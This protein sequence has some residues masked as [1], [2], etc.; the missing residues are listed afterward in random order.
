MLDFSVN[1]SLEPHFAA[2]GS[3]GF[4][5]ASLE[6]LLLQVRT[7]RPT[8]RVMFVHSCAFSPLCEPV[9]AA[10]A[11]LAALHRVPFVS[12][13]AAVRALGAELKLEPEPVGIYWAGATRFHPGAD[14]HQRIAHAVLACLMTPWDACAPAQVASRGNLTIASVDELARQQTNYAV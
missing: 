6:A 5:V 14:V 12:Y 3:T 7:L 13:P 1:D 8:L 2:P 11:R 9:A 4:S 10:T